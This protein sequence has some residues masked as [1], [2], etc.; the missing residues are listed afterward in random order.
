[1]PEPKKQT[2]KAK[3]KVRR[4]ANFSKKKMAQLAK[5]QECGEKKM[6]HQV[7]P[8]CG[9]YKDEEIVKESN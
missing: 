1:M 6:P 9:H 4:K 5:C 7:C 8:N 2:T 3:G